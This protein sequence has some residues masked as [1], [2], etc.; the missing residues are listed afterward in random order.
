MLLTLFQSQPGILPPPPPPPLPFDFELAV[1]QPAQ[2]M[3]GT[4]IKSYLYQ[5]YADDADCQSFVDAYNQATQTYVDWFNSVSLPVYSGLSGSL[6]DWVAEGLYGI[7]RTALEST[8]VA[9]MGPLNTE[10]LD[11]AA[12]NSF[13]GAVTSQFALTDDI[14]KRIITWN[15]YKGDGKRFCIRWLKRR[16]MRFLIGVNGIDPQPGMAG[17]QVGAENTSAIGARIV[18]GTLT[19]TISQSTISNLASLTPGILGIFQEAFQANVLDLPATYN[20]AV[21]IIS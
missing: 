1:Q 16:V 5:Q 2:G 21:S 20:Y 15:F 17:F 3:L 11:T 7:S 8:A 10:P 9:A 4:T 14:F 12:L 13:V 18:S 19:V 6:L